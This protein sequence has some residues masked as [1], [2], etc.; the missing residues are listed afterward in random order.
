MTTTHRWALGYIAGRARA[1]RRG[2]QNMAAIAGSV[3]MARGRGV[4]DDAITAVLQESG[5]SWDAG[6]GVIDTQVTRTTTSR[7][8]PH[9]GAS[10]PN[11]YS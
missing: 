6:K 4:P 10:T 8:L 7:A 3:A 11:P 2:N 5:L 9:P 1:F